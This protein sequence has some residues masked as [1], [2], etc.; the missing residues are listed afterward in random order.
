MAELQYGWMS[1]NVFFPS[2]PLEERACFSLGVRAHNS[3][4]CIQVMNVSERYH[5]Y[6]RCETLPRRSRFNEP[7]QR[8]DDEHWC[9]SRCKGKNA[10]TEITALQNLECFGAIPAPSDTRI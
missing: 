4:V 5:S 1:R 6:R 10:L 9:P 8:P 3:P 2:L 7:L